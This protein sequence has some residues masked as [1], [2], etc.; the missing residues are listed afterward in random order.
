MKTGEGAFREAAPGG[1]SILKALASGRPVVFSRPPRSSL[2]R[3]ADPTGTHRLVQEYEREFAR[4]FR[5]LIKAIVREVAT[6]NG[7]GL[8]RAPVTNARFKFTTRPEQVAAFASWM[9]DAV[10]RY[11]FDGNLGR[12]YDE[13]ADRF[14][15]NSFANVA[16]RRGLLNAAGQMQRAGGR[17]SPSYV[18]GAM[19]RGQHAETL[20]TLYSR[21][22]EDLR[23]ITER[24]ARGI[25]RALTEGL[26]EA[27]D[28]MAIARKIVDRVE[29]IGAYRS[30]LIAR[31]ELIS[32][33]NEAELNSFEDAGLDGVTL[34]PE[35]LTAGDERV[36]ERCEEAASKQYTLATARGL[37]PLHPNCRCAWAPIIVNGSQI[38]LS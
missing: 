6:R 3:R 23:N 17:V 35:W 5:K 37:I 32:A 12:S 14:W 27:L 13:A 24:M 15:G 7:F 22:F 31:T 34:T 8:P 11:L 26:A 38:E 25:N 16:Y 29:N 28:P 1:S 20:K 9:Q 18:A 33:F 10:N 19:S 2:A 4:R 36:C 21:S 30:K